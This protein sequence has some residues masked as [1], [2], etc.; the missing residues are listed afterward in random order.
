MLNLVW[1]IGCNLLNIMVKQVSPA[2]VV[3]NK[4]DFVLCYK[5]LIAIIKVYLEM[6]GNTH[7]TGAK[8]EMPT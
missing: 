4:I 2:F 5:L 8:I 1:C 7:L 6:Y 3:A